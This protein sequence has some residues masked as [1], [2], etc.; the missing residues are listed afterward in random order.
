MARSDYSVP[1][2]SL[3][4]KLEQHGVTVAAVNDGETIKEIWA[5]TPLAI[6][7]AACDAILAVSD[8]G[9]GVQ[10]VQNGVRHRTDLQI[11]FWGEPTDI[12][13]D[14]NIPDCEDFARIIADV[15]ADWYKLWNSNMIPWEHYEQMFAA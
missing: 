3:L 1:L 7:K 6:R 8:A 14:W 10:Y 5:G 15:A 2:M 12:L 9:V 11:T 13:R 4:Y